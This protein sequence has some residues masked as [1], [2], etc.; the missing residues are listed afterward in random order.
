MNRFFHP[1]KLN[2]FSL[3]IVGGILTALVDVGATSVLLTMGVWYITSISIGFFCALCVN[4]FFH[5]K[6]T[7]TVALSKMVV[8]K[9]LLIVMANY[10]LTLVIVMLFRHFGDGLVMLGKIASLPI[11]AIHGYL[12]SKFWV[13]KAA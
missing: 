9:Y 6:I 11:V 10:L 3:F 2:Q 13:F 5:V 12:W 4:F 7:F 8:M 1:G